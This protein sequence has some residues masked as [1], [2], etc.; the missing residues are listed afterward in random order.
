MIVREVLNGVSMIA[1]LATAA[2]HVP[3]TK[4]GMVAL[5]GTAL[6]APV[7]CGYHLMCAAKLNPDPVDCVGRKLDQ[8]FIHV[9]AALLTYGT[10][11][12]VQYTA[13]AA[14][15]NTRYIRLLWTN[16][17]HDTPK[18]RRLRIALAYAVYL[19]PVFLNNVRIGGRIFLSLLLSS[20][21]FIFDKALRGVGH[22]VF[23]LGLCA[24]W[25]D[26]AKV[27]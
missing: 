26:L 4:Y 3:A 15:L 13:A 9:A 10:S 1:P 12:S 23:H 25:Y 18:A 21:A 22:T 6:H 14:A 17:P 7:S 24:T 16:G 19:L 5:L 8:T 2:V 20:G 11:H 27:I